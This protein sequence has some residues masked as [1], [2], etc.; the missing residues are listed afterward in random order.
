MSDQTAKAPSKL[1]QI[2]GDWLGP[3]RHPLNQ[4]AKKHLGTEADPGVPYYLQLAE[5]GLNDPDLDVPKSH[6]R[7]MKSQ[8]DVLKGAPPH[9]AMNFIAPKDQNL[10]VPSDPKEAALSA[11]QQLD[12]RMTAQVAGYPPQS[13]RAMF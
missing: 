5:K 2:K 3:N 13:P 1:Q 12:S 6:R 4:A 7:M 8:L 11:A 10:D 9:H